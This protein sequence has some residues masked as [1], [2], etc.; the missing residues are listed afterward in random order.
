MT[1][2]AKVNGWAG[3]KRVVKRVGRRVA[4]HLQGNLYGLFSLADVTIM[5]DEDGRDEA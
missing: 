4:V 3:L 1:S 2:F 5:E